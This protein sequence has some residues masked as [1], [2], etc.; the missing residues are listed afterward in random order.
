ME[1]I[2]DTDAMQSLG[3]IAS[4]IVGGLAKEIAWDGKPITKNGV[5]ANIPIETYHHDTNLFNGFS[6]S[7]SGLRRLIDRPSLY[8][9]YSA[10]NPARFEETTKQPL[11][12]GKAAHMLLLGEEGF[13]E[14]Y[15]LRP[16]KYED[17]KG[18]WKPWSGNAN[19]CKTWLESQAKAKRTVITEAEIVHIKEMAASLNRHPMIRLG[20]MNGR[21]ERSIVYKDGNVWIRTRPDVIPND[22]GDFVD[23]K[24]AANLSDESLSKTIMDRGYHIQAALVRMAVRAV[25]GAEAFQSFTF[26]FVEKEPPYD[27]RVLALKD[28]D[29]DIGERLARNGIATAK[30]CLKRK[31][32]P[33][34]DGFAPEVG[35]I[36]TPSW[37]QTRIEN[38]LNLQE[39]A[40]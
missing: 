24:T 14:C 26:V 2:V 20:I 10:F 18:A 19:V 22:S 27:V 13:A 7:S 40:A 25:L 21:I 5:F 15:V 16:E 4:S 34:Y 9:A 12:F 29:I 17:D 8:W 28:R 39:K 11:E 38:T 33:G 37:Y 6:I 32:W 30:E 36:E 3:S 35:W 1:R 31:D 23:L